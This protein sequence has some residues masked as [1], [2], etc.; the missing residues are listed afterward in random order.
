MIT[1]P[2][3]ASSPYVTIHS[4]SDASTLMRKRPTVRI[5]VIVVVV[6]EYLWIVHDALYISKV[7]DPIFIKR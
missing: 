5:F 4:F 1:M 2:I 3:S 6:D 7:Q